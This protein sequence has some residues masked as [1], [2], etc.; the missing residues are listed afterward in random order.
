[1][2]WLWPLT[3]GI[4]AAQAIVSLA[5]GLVTPALGIPIAAA[6]VVLF[7]A[8]TARWGATLFIEVPAPL[9]AI[10][11]AQ[12]AS[13]GTILGRE[14]LLSQ[15]A[16]MPHLLAPAYP[17]RWRLSGAV[18]LAV[19][20]IAAVVA[21][22]FLSDYPRALHALHSFDTFADERLQERP[23]GDFL[24]GLRILPE[25]D[26]PPPPLALRND[27]SLVD[28]LQAAALSVVVTPAGATAVTLDSLD[29]ALEDERRDGATLVVALGYDRGDDG[30][31]ERDAG[32]YARRRLAAVEAIVRRVRPDVLLPVLDPGEAGRRALGAQPDAF[33]KAQLTA[34]ATVAHRL[35]PRTRVGF[36]VASYDAV[37]SVLYRWAASEGSRMD[38]VGFSLYPSYGG[39]A[40]LRARLRVA[41]SW[42]RD[43]RLTHWIFGVGANPRVF[44]ERGQERAVWGALAWAT[45]QP[46][47]Q[48]LIV[49]G[50]AD[51]E[52]LVGL[53]APGGRLRP[54][55]ATIDRARR[56]LEEAARAAQ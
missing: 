5:R 41:D 16:I 38:I 44:G 53:R 30:R 18:R 36:S 33:W 32:A 54:T 13:L 47:V 55:V 29:R 7:A 48:A 11:S 46:R 14:A 22:L 19:A 21:L 51:N 50:A 1:V 8:A 39:G 26:A 4:F 2:E 31:L 9:L 45:S 56:A 10:G 25:L 49:D 3:L 43:S 17:A 24:I 12:A 52:D 23:R 42:M 15:L 28:T 27:L 37:D 6:N 40:S 35:R 34:A 20:A